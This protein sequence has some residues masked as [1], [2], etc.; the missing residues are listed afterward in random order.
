MNRTSFQCVS[1]HIATTTCTPPRNRTWILGFEI[2]DASRYT[3]KAWKKE[4]HVPRPG[5]EPGSQMLAVSSGPLH[6][7]GFKKKIGIYI[8]P[9]QELN[10]VPGIRNPRCLPLHQQGVKKRSACTCTPPRNRTWILGLEIPDAC[11]Y[12]SR[13][14]RKEVH[15][16]VPRPGIEPGS[17]DS[18]SQMLAVTPAGREEKK[19]MYPAQESNL[20]PGIRNPRCLPL[21]QQGLSLELI[22]L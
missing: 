5:I 4:V 11:R 18:K 9:A 7:Q 3:S 6:K 19:C 20:D 8:Y 16:H 14:W 22:F 10:L 13:A 17:W 2:P 21:H 1:T 15:A 12:T